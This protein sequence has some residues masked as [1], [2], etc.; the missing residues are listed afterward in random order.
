MVGFGPIIFEKATYNTPHATQHGN[1]R[2]KAGKP[3]F[4]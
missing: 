3:Y 1:G 4:C 2:K